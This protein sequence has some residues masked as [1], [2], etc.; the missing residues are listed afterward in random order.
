M[1]LKNSSI[2][3]ISD[4]DSKDIETVFQQTRLFKSIGEVKGT[5]GEVLDFRQS[6]CHRVI[7][8]FAEASTRTRISFEM[9]CQNLGVHSILFTDLKHSSMTKGETLGGTI[10]TLESFNPSALVLRYKGGIPDFDFDKPIINAGFGSFEHPTQ[11]LVDTFTILERRDSIKGE[12]VLIVGDVLH[13]RVSN[14][15]VRLLSRLGAEVAYCSPEAL[16]PQEEFWKSIHH[17]KNLN[18]GVAWASVIMCLRVQRE[19]HGSSIGLSLAEYRDRYLVGGKQLEIFDKKGVLL[20]PGPYVSGVEIGPEI[21]GDSRCHILGQVTNSLYIRMS[22]IA[23]V[24]G[25]D[26]KTDNSSPAV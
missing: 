8:L 1:S 5:Y 13:S 16:L 23:S 7:L 4:L 18:E 26:V 12:K 19:R 20:H 22:L 6:R 24:L 25:L 17:F 9:A 21:L 14:S 11:A 3:S 15:N 2:L 10:A